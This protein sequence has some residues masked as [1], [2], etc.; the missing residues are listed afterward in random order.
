MNKKA[1]TLTEVLIV[2]V[3]LGVLAATAL[4]MLV[5]TLE[6]GMV[7]EAISNL[8]FIESA[9]K[10]YF[11]A[12]SVFSSDIDSLNIENPNSSSSRYFDYTIESADGSDFTARAQRR[13]NAPSPYDTYYYEI[14][15]GGTI[16]SEPA[17][18]PFLNY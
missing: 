1:F 14:S 2:I 3:I 11:L 15:K 17:S 18:N 13:S 8:D 10:I 12:N 9:Q 6:K 7:G 16:S 5:K 4:P